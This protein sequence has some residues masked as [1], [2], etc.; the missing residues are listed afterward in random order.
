MGTTSKQKVT[1]VPEKTPKIFV[2]IKIISI[3]HM[4]SGTADE[5]RPSIALRFCEEHKKAPGGVG[6]C[7]YEGIVAC[8]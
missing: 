6:G 4:E 1:R 8:Y 2:Q 3:G 7:S 5:A